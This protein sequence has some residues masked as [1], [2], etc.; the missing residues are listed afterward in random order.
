MEYRYGSHTV[1]QIEYH[2]V[3][4]K[5]CRPQYLFFTCGNSSNSLL[6]VRPLI[7]RMIS[8][9]AIVG[10]ELTRICT[11]SLLTTPFTILISKA[12]HVDLTNSRTR[13]ATSPVNT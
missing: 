6:D 9:G 4:V 10:G 2:F 8:L 3:W 5:K 1:F 11:R 12:S 7:R 13:S